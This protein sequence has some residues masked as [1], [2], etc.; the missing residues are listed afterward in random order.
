MHKATALRVLQLFS[1]LPATL[2]SVVCYDI[3]SAMHP[4]I[5]TPVDC[6]T[7]FKISAKSGGGSNHGGDHGGGHGPN[8]GAKHD[9]S[10]SPNHDD[11]HDGDGSSGSSSNSGSYSANSDVVANLPFFNF[12]PASP[13]SEILEAEALSPPSWQ[14]DSQIQINL[15]CQAGPETCYAMQSTLDLAA[16]YVSQII[17]FKAPLQV[18]ASLTDFCSVYGA[19]NS[20][21]DTDVILGGA[22]P[23]RTFPLIDDDGTVRYYP[24]AVVR[25]MHFPS[26]QTPQ[27]GPSDVLMEFNSN[28]NFHYEKP[29]NT[30]IQ[31]DQY[32]FLTVAIHEYILSSLC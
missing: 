10:D 17:Q 20:S 16:W 9:R 24:Q 25:Q 8:N 21:A 23:A 11:D 13:L 15:N 6:W 28:V 19:C 27:C 14:S 29:N 18:N 32:D 1:L 4:E 22:V 5:L 2:A 12:A 7:G 30:T 31:P 3:A 26:G